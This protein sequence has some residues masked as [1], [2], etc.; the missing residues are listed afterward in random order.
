MN[1]R[2]VKSAVPVS[3][4][5]RMTV[6]DVSLFQFSTEIR[7]RLPETDAMGIV[8][9]GCF[10][11]YL[12]VG[13]TDYL[14]NLGLMDGVRPIK[15]FS[16]LV[17]HVQCD[18]LSSAR[19]DDPL[20]IHVRLAAIGITSFRFEFLIRHKQENRMVAWGESVHVAIEDESMRPIPVPDNFRDVTRAFERGHLVEYQNSA[21]S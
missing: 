4:R 9:H 15:G 21:I 20:V 6:P 12:D 19:F 2:A 14:R 1:K 3:S 7:V 18:F 5:T 13:R 8:F 10:F 17:R 16:N 11:T